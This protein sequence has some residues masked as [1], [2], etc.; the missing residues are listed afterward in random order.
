MH[1][2]SDDRSLEK[3]MWIMWWNVVHY[4]HFLFPRCDP[5]T[6]RKGEGY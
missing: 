1:S 4:F 6:G 3:L 5:P 2:S